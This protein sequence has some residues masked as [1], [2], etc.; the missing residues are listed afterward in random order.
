MTELSQQWL[1]AA[2]EPI[3]EDGLK[4][5]ITCYALH[6][7]E[8][9]Y[10]LAGI[11]SIVDA[12]VSGYHGTV[13]AYGQT[14]GYRALISIKHVYLLIPRNAN[15]QLFS[16]GHTITTAIIVLG[17]VDEYCMLADR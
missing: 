11:Q 7:Q 17:K 3:P 4:I 9:V 1:R 13:L 6:S 10:E 2:N 8:Q 12:V 16:R 15:N 14:G 5:C